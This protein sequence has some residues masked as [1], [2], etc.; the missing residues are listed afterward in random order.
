MDAVHGRTA[1]LNH[2]TAA[3]RPEAGRRIPPDESARSRILFSLI[4][5]ETAFVQAPMKNCRRV[6]TPAFAIDFREC[7]MGRQINW[8]YY[9][10][11]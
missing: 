6:G 9:R 11:G 3:Y 10:K 7:T 2:D 5:D 4:A 8:Y 1:H